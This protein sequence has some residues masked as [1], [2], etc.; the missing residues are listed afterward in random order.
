MLL[1]ERAE[2]CAVARGVESLSVFSEK[3]GHLLTFAADLVPEGE[4]FSLLRFLEKNVFEP[5]ILVHCMSGR[6]CITADA[7]A[8][9][10]WRAWYRILFE[11]PLIFDEAF[12]MFHTLF[13]R[14]A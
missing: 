5:N 3:N 2:V 8:H 11:L 6:P 1:D 4:D 13:T 9:K 14:G 12:L 10:I 7:P